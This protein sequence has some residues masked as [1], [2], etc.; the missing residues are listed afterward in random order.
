MIEKLKASQPNVIRILENSI[1]NNKVSHA[2]LF[3]GPKG[4]YKKEMAYHLALM[5]YEGIN[6]DYE[7]DL[8]KQI[9]SG[10]HLNV[11]YIEPQIDASHSIKK[12]QILALQEEFSKTSQVEGPR[13]YIINEA[14]TMNVASANSLLKFIEEPVNEETYGIL[15]T[16]HADNILSTIRSRSITINFKTSPKS[17]LKAELVE[18]GITEEESDILAYLVN[19]KTEADLILENEDY[20]EVI[21]TFKHFT[22]LINEEKNITLF[23]RMNLKVLSNRENLKNFLVLLE[24]LYRDAL[25]EALNDKVINFQTL[26]LTA[27]KISSTKSLEEIED[28]INKILKLE[29]QIGYNVTIGLN[30][31]MLFVDLNGG[32]L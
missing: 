1:K 26:E 6:P 13:I 7:S 28:I 9:L 22:E 24:G 25:E 20:N 18:S 30:I 31:D 21:N 32:E 4:T 16:E 11:T 15:L 3:A 17:I 8:A 27:K 2:Y 12:E 14:D 10:N 19:N 29:N 5:L 23:Y